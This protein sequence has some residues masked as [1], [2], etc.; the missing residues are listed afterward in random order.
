MKIKIIKSSK[1]LVKDQIKVVSD[2]VG[3]VLAAKGLA[4]IEGKAKFTKDIA[5]LKAKIAA[6]KNAPKDSKTETKPK[7]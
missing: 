5:T 7:K 4:T 6:K 3:I 1:G 2:Q